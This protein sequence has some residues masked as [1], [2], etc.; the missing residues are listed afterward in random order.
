MST[1]QRIEKPVRLNLTQRLGAAEAK[2]VE[3]PILH[4]QKVKGWWLI[5]PVGNCKLRGRDGPDTNA[6]A[7]E[8]LD[9]LEGGDPAITRASD[10]HDRAQ[11]PAPPR[12]RGR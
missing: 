9:L 1:P 6:A 10:T 7:L 8:M 12:T 5:T 3:E 11:A 2:I 4:G